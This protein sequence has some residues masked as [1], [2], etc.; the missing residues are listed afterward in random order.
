[1]RGNWIDAMAGLIKPLLIF[2]SDQ[3]FFLFVTICLKQGLASMEKSNV[4]FVCTYIYISL[5]KK[6]EE[7]IKK[8]LNYIKHV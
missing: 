4:I 6:R 1:M 8:E 7:E 3:N 5:D 2:L